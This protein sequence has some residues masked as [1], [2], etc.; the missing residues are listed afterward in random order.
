MDR[1]SRDKRHTI[2]YRA[3]ETVTETRRFPDWFMYWEDRDDVAEIGTAISELTRTLKPFERLYK[4]E[5]LERAFSMYRQIAYDHL[6]RG[7]VA[8]K[9]ENDELTSL[10]SMAVHDLRAPVRSIS[11]LLK[12]YIADAGDKIDPEFLEISKFLDGSLAR[13]SGLVDGILEHFEASAQIKT[14]AVNTGE[15]IDEIANALKTGEL[16]CEIV[17]IGEFPT[18][19]AN[20]LK[21]WRVLNCL[22]S[23][24]LKYNQS[25][26]PRVE[27]SVEQDELEWQFCIRDNGIGIHPKH[28]Q[29][30]FEIFQRLHTH[31]AYPGTGVGLATCRKLVEQWHGKIWVASN[32]SNGSQFYFTYPTLI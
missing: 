30:V 20:S 27:I 16:H 32:E 14:E 17:K 6:L 25:E 9:S 8:V 24:G 13:M 22:I 11:G 21:V 5:E 19:Q 10:L 18:I 26:I 1:I 3:E 12:L 28:Q 29:R 7:L 23:N 31:T 2:F 15:I 4:N